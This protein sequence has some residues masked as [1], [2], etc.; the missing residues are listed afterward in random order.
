MRCLIAS[1]FN[2]AGID[3]FDAESDLLES[4]LN[5]DISIDSSPKIDS[6]LDE[7]AG[8][9]IFLDSIPPGIDKASFDPEKKIWIEHSL[10]QDKRSTNIACPADDSLP[11]GIESDDFDSENDD[12]ST[13]TPE[14]ESFHVD[15]PD[16]GDST[17]DAVEDIPVHVPN[18]LPKEKSPSSSHRGCKASKLF[19]HKSSM[20]IPADNI[21]ILGVRQVHF[22]SFN[23]AL[24][25]I[26][27]IVKALVFSVLS[28]RSLELQI[29][30][31][32]LGI[33]IS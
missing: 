18:N 29:L 7:F 27:R 14:F 5:R 4:M 1:L 12:N 11:P 13:S 20:L 16:L 28:I 26:A 33:P 15:Y 17:I 8:E 19:H 9:L 32:I 21:P 24:Y 23:K 25:G 31:F 3:P 30:S 22:S 10:T 2:S 6:L